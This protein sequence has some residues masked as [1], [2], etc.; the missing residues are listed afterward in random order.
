MRSLSGSRVL[1]TGANSGIGAE[2][3]RQLADRGADVVLLAADRRG[4]ARVAEAVTSAGGRAVVTTAELTDLAGVKRAV[5]RGVAELGGLD[6]VIVNAAA[7]SYGEFRETPVEDVRRTIDITLGGAI[8]VISATLPQ[9]ERSAGTLVVT[10]SVAGLQPLP[11]FAG[12]SAAE[13]GLRGLV[14]SIR[15]ELL[16][17]GAQVRVAMVHPAP[18]RTP[19]W[20]TLDPAQTMSPDLPLA[21]DPESVA[22]A[23][24]AAIGRPRAEQTLGLAVKASRVVRAVARPLHDLGLAAAARWALDHAGPPP[25]SAVRD[26]AGDG[27][28]NDRANGHAGALPD[29]LVAGL[30]EA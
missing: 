1:V 29:A 26:P 19:F 17:A 10:G 4:L 8:N 20:R 18:V 6:A 28:A 12:H 11:L 2:A 15:I 30:H 7:A 25:G 13:H 5:D 9:L 22:T 3:V 24:V 27:A 14:Q 23:L 16:A 21:Y